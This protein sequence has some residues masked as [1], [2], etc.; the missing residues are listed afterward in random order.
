MYPAVKT[1][2]W[3]LATKIEHSDDQN[4]VYLRGAGTDLYLAPVSA[5]ESTLDNLLIP[6]QGAKNP[7]LRGGSYGTNQGAQVRKSSIAKALCANKCLGYWRNNV[8]VTD[9]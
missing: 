7:R 4:P 9:T 8:R 2:D 1:G 3:G 5:V 6:A